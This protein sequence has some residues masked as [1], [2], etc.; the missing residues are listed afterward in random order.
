MTMTTHMGHRGPIHASPRL[1]RKGRPTLAIPL[2]ISFAGVAGA[3]AIYFVILGEPE[4]VATDSGEAAIVQVEEG[5]GA[6]DGATPAE[7]A[8]TAEGASAQ[9]AADPA[10][11]RTAEGASDGAPATAPA[12]GA[13]TAEGDAAAG[14][15]AQSAPTAPA[16]GDAGTATSGDQESVTPTP[17]GP[18]GRDGD[19]TTTE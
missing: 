4:Q 9:P 7:G 19:A 10:Q 17:S 12:A 1:E 14:T 2:A 11:A 13:T 8:A 18:A 15:S 3:I 6:A 16:A 5:A